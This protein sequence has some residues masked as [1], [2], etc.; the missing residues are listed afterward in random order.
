MKA[1]EIKNLNKIYDDFELKDVSFDVYQGTVMGLIGANGSGKTTILKSILSIIK[2]DGDIR[3][4][5]EEISKDIKDEINSVFEEYFIGEYLNAKEVDKIYSEIYSKW[6]S[7]YFYELLDKFDIATDKKYKDF[8]K[9][10]KIKL[11][12]AIALSSR[13]KLLIL[14]EPTSGLDPVIRSEILD[15]FLEYMEDENNTILISSHITTDLEKIADYITFINDGE[16][17]FTEEKYDLEENYGIVRVSEEDFKKIDKRFIKK[18]KKEKYQINVLV[19][20]LHEFEKTYPS[21][22]VDRST[23][24]EIMVLYLRGEEA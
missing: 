3:I 5:G 8:S 17:I 19:D 24:D 11:K 15:I 18:F 22:V 20:N 13:P 7:N 12:I 21:F 16:V 10:M 1:I 2:Y 4:L 23:I 9:G 14:D 6:D